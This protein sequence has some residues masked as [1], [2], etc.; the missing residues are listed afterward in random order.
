MFI[1][2]TRRFKNWWQSDYLPFGLL[3]IWVNLGKLMS[4]AN[5][6]QACFGVHYSKNNG[7]SSRRGDIVVAYLFKC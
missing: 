2:E 3:Q 7:M 1:Q 6:F 5:K 4:C